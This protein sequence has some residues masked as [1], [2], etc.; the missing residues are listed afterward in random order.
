MNAALAGLVP[1]LRYIFL[2]DGILARLTED[3][4]DAVFLHE[5]AHARYH[6][7]ALRILLVLSPLSLWHA[8]NAYHPSE[9]PL[10]AQLAS[11]WGMEPASMSSLITALGVAAYL[12]ITLSW[13]SRLLEHQADLWA[14][15]QLALAHE[16]RSQDSLKEAVARYVNTLTRL[17]G[18]DGLHSNRMEW[19]HPSLLLRVEFLTRVASEPRREVSFH[20]NVRCVGIF[21]LVI[22]ISPLALGW[23]LV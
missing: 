1:P 3:D 14:C 10:V 17:L 16:S 22:A 6:H 21:I 5:A 11:A 15:R 4:I 20:R 8:A 12:V 13:Y 7:L 2:T 18:D 23:L 9:L 19:L